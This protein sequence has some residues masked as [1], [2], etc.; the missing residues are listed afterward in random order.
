MGISAFR[1]ETNIKKVREK[2]R[3][4]KNFQYVMYV[5]SDGITDKN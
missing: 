5:S 4:K 1:D 3:E 2:K